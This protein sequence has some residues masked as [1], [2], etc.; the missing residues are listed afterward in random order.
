MKKTSFTNLRVLTRTALA[1]VLSVLCS[2]F[3]MAQCQLNCND[4]VQV[5]LNQNCEAIITYDLMLEDP[6]NP[7]TC[8]PNGPSAYAVV[9]LDD[10][11][12]PRN[13]PGE[14]AI[15]TCDDIDN[16]L[17]VKVKHWASGNFCWG[18]ITVED[19]IAPVI[20]CREFELW[21]NEDPSIAALGEPNV[22]DNCDDYPNA[23]DCDVITLEHVQDTWEDLDCTSD[24]ISAIITREWKATD[25]SGNWTTCEEVIILRRFEL[26]VGV[27]EH[28]D[29]IPNPELDLPGNLDD[30]AGPAIDCDTDCAD[31]FRRICDGTADDDDLRASYECAGYPELHHTWLGLNGDEYYF[32]EINVTHDDTCIEIC[33]DDPGIGGDA[34]FKVL[35]DWRILDWCTGDILE[36]TQIIKIIDDETDIICPED[37]A[38]GTNLGATAC[39][40]FGNLPAATPNENCADYTV[41]TEIWG[42]V[43]HGHVW[44]YELIETIPGNGGLPS[45]PLY[46]YGCE[47]EYTIRY[48]IEDDCHNHDYC[49]MTLT[50]SDDDAPTP[51][52]DEITQVTLDAFPLAEEDADCGD[53]GATAIVYAET[54]DDGSHDNCSDELHFDVRRMGD[55][56][57]GPFVV[58]DCGDCGES[59]MVEFRA[60]DECGN[61]S[62]SCMVEVLVDDKT[63]P[64]ITCPDNLVLECTDIADAQDNDQVKQYL[65]N[66]DVKATAQDNCCIDRIECRI[67]QNTVDECGVGRVR[68]QY[69]AYDFGWPDVNSSN[70]IQTIDIE[71]NTPITVQFPPDRTLFCDNTDGG[72]F[73]GGTDPEDLGAPFDTVRINGDDC[74]LIAVN[75][76]DEFFYI[77]DGA[78]F[79]ILRRWVVI[80]W[81]AYDPNGPQDPSNGYYSEVQVIK[82]L[83]DE[84]P[85]VEEIEDEVVCIL[86]G[87]SVDVDIC[88]PASE[89]CVPEDHLTYEYSGDLGTGIISGDCV[90]IPDV[91][92]GTYEI[93]INVYDN[94]GNATKRTYEVKVEDCKKPSPYCVN[95]LV[96]ELMPTTGMIDTWAVDFDAGSFDNCPGDLQLSFSSDVSDIGAVFTCDDLGTQEVELWVTDAAGNQDFCITFVIIQDNMGGCPTDPGTGGLVASGTVQTEMNENVQDVMVSVN[97]G[98]QSM[99]TD[100]SG[101]FNFNLPANGDYSVTAERDNDYLNGITTFDL[102]KLR[103]HILGVE[104]LDSP[105]KM[106]AADVNNSQSIS[107]FDMV[108]LRK[109]ILQID[110]EFAN[111]TSW[112]FVDADYNFIDPANPWAEAFPEVINYNDLTASDLAADFVAIKIGDLNDSATANDLLGSEDRSSNGQLVFA[113]ADQTLNAG[114]TYTV[115]FS[116][117]LENVEGYQFTLNFD[118]NALE[119]TNIVNG[120]AVAENFGTTFVSEGAITTS[121]NG[122]AADKNAFALTFTAT[123]NVQ[124]SEVLS[125]SSRYVAAEAY[126]AGDLLDV[127]IQFNND[128]PVAAGFELYQNT[129]NPFNGVTN[130]SFNLAEAGAATLRVHD[131]TGKVITMVR[132]DYAQGLNTITMSKAQLNATGVLYYTLETANETATR[133]MIVIK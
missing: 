117:D 86:D 110:T 25:A 53:G 11:G 109:L 1:F 93:I 61:V 14:P 104:L 130:I 114:Q 26:C 78:C 125:I 89:D 58:F 40:W 70:C 36:F 85:V 52:C 111:N 107:T 67:I 126:K 102:V 123:A 4:N 73:G 128:A 9:I 6:D 13:E 118:K 120:V 19:K 129:P 35:R 23:V 24:G 103:K 99:M 95:G 77:S 31:V 57:W 94:C 116:A 28:W 41:T 106:I 115:D 75:H 74:E 46:V 51:V 64:I 55:S 8:T 22:T 87:C 92:I 91:G 42:P 133:K 108:V 96:L 127:A 54:F 71:D 18:S 43:Q 10:H 17:T 3:A 16:T 12:H 121:W 63:P 38:V 5:S 15:V 50:I 68:V 119:L 83:D 44:I 100:A 56:Q 131:V 88:R 97:G 60:T 124:L 59:V 65:D 79:K 37:L 2:N 27:D 98:D 48:E 84:A 122:T 32:C 105:Y 47:T 62:E 7:N 80:N 132:G 72:G 29:C 34:S 112:R 101:L 49:E 113:V 76:F 81:C 69:T 21:C 90:T 30:I 45:E 20:E 82:V 66:N 33:G 39:G